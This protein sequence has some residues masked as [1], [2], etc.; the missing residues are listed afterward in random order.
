MQNKQHIS[1]TANAWLLDFGQNV[2]AV[3]GTRVLL[4]LVD[5]PN[6]L[7]VPVAPYHCRNV[8]LWRKK[9][10]PVMDIAARLGGTAQNTR[11]LTVVGYQHHETETVRFGA[12]F[13]EKP[14]VA[15]NVTDTQF[16]PLPEEQSNW[17]KFA[18]SCF[19]HEGVA[20][21]IINLDTIFM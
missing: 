5:S 6:V 19:A 2:R 14:P 4:Q 15:I 1:P 11:L 16:C 20:T 8:F 9:L 13:L 18:I 10:L 7:S 21:P 17:S 12:L 3:V